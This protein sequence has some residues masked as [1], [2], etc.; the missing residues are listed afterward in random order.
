MVGYE[1]QIN[2]ENGLK[3]TIDWI[4]QPDNLKKYKSNIYNV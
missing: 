4:T 3:K 1:P 2:F